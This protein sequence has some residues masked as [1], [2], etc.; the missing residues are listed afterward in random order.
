M[1]AVVERHRWH[2]IAALAV[3]ATCAAPAARADEIVAKNSTL[4]GSI[5]GITAKGAEIETEFA[6]ARV[7]VPFTDMRD[8]TTDGAF[9]VFHGEDQEATGRLLG[10]RE[11]QAHGGPE[12]R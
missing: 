10:I 3:V 4:H 12:S 7:S 1:S 11:R 2:L 6:K 5:T 8:I 9:R